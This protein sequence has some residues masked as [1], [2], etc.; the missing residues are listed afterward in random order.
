MPGTQATEERLVS[1]MFEKEVS[2]Q[3]TPP[4]PSDGQE[5]KILL[6]LRS[7]CTQGEGAAT[8]LQEINL[9]ICTGEI[10]GIAGVSGNGQKELGD[11]VSMEHY[12]RPK[13]PVRQGL[14]AAI[15]R[16]HPQRRGEFHP[17][18]FT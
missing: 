10:V 17:R 6:E 15:N 12:Q 5:T 1:L 4:A 13:N 18:K 11:M 3:F 7:A 14:H 9:N 16:R 8:S 2:T